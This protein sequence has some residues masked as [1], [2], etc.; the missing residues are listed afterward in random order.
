LI[1]TLTRT[2]VS[3]ITLAAAQ[4]AMAQTG[5]APATG[6]QTAAAATDQGIAEIVVTAT[7]QATNLQDTPLSITAVTAETL[8]ERGLSKVSDLSAAVPNATFRRVQGAFGPG[9][10]AFI[11]GIG[12]ADT[13]LGSE[14]SVAYY[15][16]DIYYPLILGSNF[17]L[18]DLDHIEV[19][20]GPQGTLFGRNALAGA[21]NIVSRQPSLTDSSAFVQV[22]T[23]SYNRLD[24]RAGFSVP[25]ADW[26]ALSVSGMSK[27]RD[28]Y[29]QQLDFRCEMERRGTPELAGTL[30]YAD[31]INTNANNF[32]PD[33][34]RIGRFGG[35]DVRAVRGT[36]LL[37]PADN[38]KLTLNADYIRDRSEN[39]ADQLLSVANP[40]GANLQRQA[41]SFG[42]AY[43][44]RFLTGDRFTTYATY[45]DPTGAG[46]VI[47]DS[48]FHNGRPNRGGA[49]FPKNTRL[50]NWGVSGRLIVG[51]T[52]NIDATAIVGYRKMTEDHAFD[53]DGSP[54]VLEQTL[55]NIGEDYLNAEFR[56]AG[57]SSLVDWVVGAFY[58][59]GDGFTHAITYSPQSGFY[60]IQNI[61]YKPES[62]AVFA[63]VTVKPFENFNITG[64]LR[65]SDDEKLV[66]F[67]NVLDTNPVPGPGD[68]IFVVTPKAKR[69]DWK[70]GADYHV[71]DNV[72]VFA[73]ASTGARLPG[74]NPR[75]QQPTQVVTF[76]GDE[77]QAYEL[78]VKADL[79]DRRL[80]VN[81]TGF[82]TDY[83]SRYTGVTGA[84]PNLILSPDGNPVPGSQ[85][86]VPNPA[87]G[88]GATACRPYDAAADGPPDLGAGIGVTC[89]PRTYFVNTPGKVKGFEVEVEA[90]PIDGLMINAALGYAHFTSPDLKNPARANDRLA[91][92]P[93]WNGTLGVQYE[94]PVPTGSVTPRVD[95]FY[96]GNIKTSAV[97]NT[98]NQPAYSLFNGRITYHNDEHDFSVVLGATN[99]F[100]KRYYYN[101]FIYQDIGFPNVNGQ[102]G[103]P[104][105]WYLEVN[106]KF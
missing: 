104:R 72:M 66:D 68:T 8:E 23:G 52:D 73:S 74:Y 49:C 5:G 3:I 79:F 45:C 55:L 26:A 85:T 29:Q 100:N 105:E 39:P 64:G 70:I 20:R 81:A 48:T 60:K 38:V 90:R 84:E 88:P 65:R 53:I 2:S 28:G 43:D 51:V 71:T 35:E 27:K 57:K 94:I 89:I 24:L 6:E 63:N 93:E 41:G 67:S 50:D 32:S 10:S 75:P 36:L 4:V 21:V 101:F 96:T 77:T 87:G 61:T 98:Y 54:L 59:K 56:L 15:I 14:P 37:A 99:L 46:V 19:L 9:V 31:A 1:R 78:G 11:R 42:V 103:R 91:G 12:Q 30:P 102:P 62:K 25:L 44:E 97:R 83:K 86:V 82:Y 47:P 34:C 58:F 13:S 76:D 80:R 106:K 17:D 22:T 92:L 33:N 40:G 16:D 7:R 95:W 18:L 69:W